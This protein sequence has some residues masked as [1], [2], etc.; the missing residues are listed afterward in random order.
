MYH[1]SEVCMRVHDEM[2]EWF[3]VK[4]GVSHGLPHVTMAF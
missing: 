3:E 4:Q 2:S 1:T